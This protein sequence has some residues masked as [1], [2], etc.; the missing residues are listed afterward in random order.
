M[1]AI[2]GKIYAI[3]G[4]NSGIG[5]ATAET[6]VAGGAAVAILGRDQARLAATEAELG[7]AALAVQGD[8]TR[9]DDVRR[10]FELI[11]ACFGALDGL[12]VN[13]GAALFA[14]L[15][16]LTEAQIHGLLAVNVV[17]AV[18]TVQHALPLLRYGASV[19]LN[20]SMLADLGVPG[21]SI[22]AASKAAVASLARSL[23]AELLG[24][25]IR[26]NT[27]SPGNI[28]TPLYDRLGMPPEQL[29]AALAAELA[30]IPLGRF[31][32]AEEVAR[33]VVFL[34]SPES[35]YIVGETL[36]VDG[37]RSRL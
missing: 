18:S 15:E 20:S 23:S 16:T 13:A 30:N 26:V 3:T 7:A 2:E 21:A 19:V 11:A 28:R 33:T 5:R 29:D 34:L 4:G 37:G 6:L 31:G 10:F 12:F 27:V 36:V 25:G 1:S 24:R 8:V 35:G 9:R 32:S 17:G 14:P 22:Y